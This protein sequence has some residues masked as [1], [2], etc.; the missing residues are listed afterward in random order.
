MR[1]SNVPMDDVN[2]R[3]SYAMAVGLRAIADRE[4]KERETASM[5]PPPTGNIE[6]TELPALIGLEAEVF[7]ASGMSRAE[8][9]KYQ[10]DDSGDVEVP[11]G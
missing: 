4:K 11:L 2:I 1:S 3:G 6:T 9:G 5:D 10:A 7:E 8:W